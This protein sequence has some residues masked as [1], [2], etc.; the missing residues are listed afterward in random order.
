MQ[1]LR[2]NLALTRATI[3]VAGFHSI[4][5]AIAKENVGWHKF[6]RAGVEQWKEGRKED[7]KGKTLLDV[8]IELDRQNGNPLVKGS[9]PRPPVARTRLLSA[10][11]SEHDNGMGLG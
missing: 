9:P 2:G 7:G 4:Q 1:I 5:N 11:E 3:G 6:N 8:G 10:A